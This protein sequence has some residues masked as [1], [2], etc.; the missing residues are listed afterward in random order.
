MGELT[1]IWLEVVEDE[2]DDGEDEVVD[3]DEVEEDEDEEDVETE[4]VKAGC[5]D[6]ICCLRFLIVRIRGSTKPEPSI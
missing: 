3:E 4:A 5:S 1:G 6:S 2:E